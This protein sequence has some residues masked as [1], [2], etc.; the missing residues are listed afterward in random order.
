[1]AS[2]EAAAQCIDE[3]NGDDS[4]AH[5]RGRS[6][7]AGTST[8]TSKTSSHLRHEQRRRRSSVGE[9]VLQSLRCFGAARELNV[10]NGPAASA[11]AGEYEEN[12][13][14]SVAII[15]RISTAHVQP[16][17]ELSGFPSAKRISEQFSRARR[18][19]TLRRYVRT[20]SRIAIG[21]QSLEEDEKSNNGHSETIGD[22]KGSTTFNDIQNAQVRLLHRLKSMGL[23][24]VIMADDG[25]GTFGSCFDTWAGDD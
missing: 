18:V 21:L 2:E 13:E 4:D 6:T 24:Q 22:S 25:N 1:M 11:D 19:A 3:D 12:G 17:Q 16:P 23:T 8:S 5:V 7:S 20:G 14:R 10:D 15:R 9:R